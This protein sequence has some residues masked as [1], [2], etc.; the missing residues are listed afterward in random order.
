M[1]RFSAVMAWP[2]PN[3]PISGD[4]YLQKIVQ[5]PFHL[6]PLVSGNLEAFI[7]KLDEKSPAQG[8]LDGITQKVFAEGLLPNPRQVKRALNIFR[9]L[10]A[11]AETRETNG[12]LQRESV[13]WPLLAKT[14]VIQT[15]YPT[16][17][18]HWR[19][20]PRLIQRLEREYSENPVE[21][22]D[23]ERGAFAHKAGGEDGYRQI[24]DSDILA[25]YLNDR[26]KYALLARMLSY[27]PQRGGAGG[28]LLARFQSLDRRANGRLCAPGRGGGSE[29]AGGECARPDLGRD[30]QRR[31]GQN[32][33]C[34][35]SLRRRGNRCQRPQN[36]AACASSFCR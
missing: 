3:Y 15:Q 34:P 31:H 35:R 6:P 7:A 24:P 8:K 18:R 4:A 30:S 14:V 32:R 11:V 5:I 9:L 10:R 16:L 1:A 36:I 25:P 33:R 23:L 19:Q 12:S 27:P 13:A 2:G 28:R 20:Y 17:Y 29:S 22:S 21:E 26:R